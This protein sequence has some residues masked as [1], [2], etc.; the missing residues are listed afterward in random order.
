MEEEE[1]E[2]EEGWRKVMRTLN[3]TECSGLY[4]DCKK[5]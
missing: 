1:E 3:Y 2:E 5:V 4:V